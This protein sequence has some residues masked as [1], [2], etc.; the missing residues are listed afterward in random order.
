MS[1]IARM[2]TRES[3]VLMKWK[4]KNLVIGK[5]LKENRSRG[6]RGESIKV[7]CCRTSDRMLLMEGS[8]EICGMTQFKTLV[9]GLPGAQFL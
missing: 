6:I 7:A 8:N 9:E 4:L 1:V 3:Y 5:I 2:H